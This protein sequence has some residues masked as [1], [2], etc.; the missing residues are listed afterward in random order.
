MN[1]EQDQYAILGVPPSATGQE[2]RSAYR[3]QVRLC[4]PD[5][6]TEPH[7]VERFRVVRE[8]YRVLGDPTSRADYDAS[9]HASSETNTTKLERAHRLAEARRMFPELAHLSESELLKAAD[10]HDLSQVLSTW[11]AAHPEGRSLKF[12]DLSASWA[13]EERKKYAISLSL[14][15]LVYLNLHPDRA[16]EFKIAQTWLEQYEFVNWTAED[17]LKFW[18]KKLVGAQFLLWVSWMALAS[19][20]VWGVATFLTVTPKDSFFGFGP[21][22]SM[23]RAF[24]NSTSG[25]LILGLVVIAITAIIVISVDVADLEGRLRPSNR[26]SP[27]GRR[28]ETER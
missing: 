27:A 20:A 26:K 21:R 22:E 8:A 24:L 5:V 11:L 12:S 7:A 2:I 28:G 16:T 19:V 15:N 4:H 3:Q 10:D 9:R 14:E 6:S 18:R 1:G 23:W 25:P 13:A 17:M